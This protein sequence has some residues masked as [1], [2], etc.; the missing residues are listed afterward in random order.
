M[1]AHRPHG[2]YCPNRRLVRPPARRRSGTPDDWEHAHRIVRRLQARIVKA[3]SGRP[4]GQGESLATSADPLVERALARGRASDG[5]P[6]QEHAGRG[7][8]HLGHPGEEGDGRTHAASSGA[9]TRNRCDACTFPRRTARCARSAFR[10]CAIERCR[11]STC[12]PS[13]P[14]PSA[15]PTPTPTGSGRARSPADAIGQCFRVLSKKALCPMDLGGR[16]QSLLRRD[17]P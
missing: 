7:R 17:Q 5:K 6:R 10:P 13:T 3:T 4:M 11:P 2:D 15:R 8:K 16:Y 9:I 12:W 14:S 1:T